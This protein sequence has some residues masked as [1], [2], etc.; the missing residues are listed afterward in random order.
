[1]LAKNEARCGHGQVGRR[2]ELLLA[3]NAHKEEGAGRPGGRHISCPP[4]L[5]DAASYRLEYP[6]ELEAKR[7]AGRRT[8]VILRKFVV[9]EFEEVGLK[10]FQ[11]YRPESKAS[12]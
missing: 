3:I 10:E 1:M 5:S 9:L 6:A 4:P 11:L 8:K 12:C 2:K 7:D